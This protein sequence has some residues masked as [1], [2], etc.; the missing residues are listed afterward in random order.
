[1][2]FLSL[3]ILM[4]LF[5]DFSIRIFVALSIVPRLVSYMLRL[6]CLFLV[7]STI[8]NLVMFRRILISAVLR[9]P[10][11]WVLPVLVSPEY[12][13]M[14][15][16]CLVY[17]NFSLRVHLFSYSFWRFLSC[18]CNAYVVEDIELFNDP[19]VYWYLD[20]WNLQILPVFLFSLEIFR[21]Y[22]VATLNKSHEVIILF[23]F[24]HNYCIVSVTCVFISLFSS[25]I[26][27]PVFWVGLLYIALLL[28]WDYYLMLWSHTWITCRVVKCL[29]MYITSTCDQF[30][31]QSKLCCSHWF[32]ILFQ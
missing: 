4:I 2:G 12:V 9:I 17:Y 22:I 19:F 32:C 29:N 20:R 16:A 1:M 3:V 28:T 23:V 5:N 6:F 31:V 13:I 14:C 10:F 27:F 21:C 11:V 26:S 15:H 24:R 25:F 30:V 7:I 18:N 8:E